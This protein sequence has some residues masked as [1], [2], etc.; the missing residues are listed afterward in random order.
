MENL[1]ASSQNPRHHCGETGTASDEQK[2]KN[3]QSGATPQSGQGSQ[4]QQQQTAAST[5]AQ[6]SS[7]QAEADNSSRRLGT[8]QP[9]TPEEIKPPEVDIDFR[10]SS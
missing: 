5:S 10:S 2:Q 7:G 3:G 4:P 8:V 1:C 9:I 6:S